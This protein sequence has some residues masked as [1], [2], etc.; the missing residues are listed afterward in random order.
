[1]QMLCS[2]CFIYDSVAVSRGV[3]ENS[4]NQI[5]S[6]VEGVT[7]D[8]SI[9]NDRMLVLRREYENTLGENSYVLRK[10]WILTIRHEIV[11]WHGRFTMPYCNATRHYL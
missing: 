5:H 2:N 10:I 4:L 6:M 8:L 7:T 11:S 9:S 1:M 3:T